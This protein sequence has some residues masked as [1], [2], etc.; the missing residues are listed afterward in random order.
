MEENC[1]ILVE[2]WVKMEE[3]GY[4]LCGKTDGTEWFLKIIKKRQIQ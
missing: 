4:K 2:K 1:Q 3:N